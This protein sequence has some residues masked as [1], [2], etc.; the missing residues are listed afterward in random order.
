M[1]TIGALIAAA[2]AQHVGGYLAGGI[3]GRFDVGGFGLKTA[4][5]VARKAAVKRKEKRA[6][7]AREDTV[8][9]LD[10]SVSADDA[11]RDIT[12]GG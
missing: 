12:A 7:E 2:V 9:W 5:A 3:L 10:R 11:S 4:V 6:V 8:E 1:G